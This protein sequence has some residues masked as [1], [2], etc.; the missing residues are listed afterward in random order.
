MV[1]CD[2]L[3]SLS[4]FL[5]SICD[6]IIQWNS[7]SLCK[8]TIFCL[9]IHKLMILG[10]FHFS[11][12]MNKAF[13]NIYVQVLCNLTFSFLLSIY[14][15]E[16]QGYMAIARFFKPFN[17]LVLGCAGSLLLCGLSSSCGEQ[18]LLSGGSAWASHYGGSL[19]A[20]CAVHGL[21]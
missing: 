1:F 18:G 20:G 6:S 19:V 7:I 4:M 14:L 10:H 16:L 21:Q 13:V 9:S 15:V 2:W 8:Y 3:L 12:I 17:L 5:R 11:S